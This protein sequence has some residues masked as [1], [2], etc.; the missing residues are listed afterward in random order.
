MHSGRE[1]RKSYL[2]LLVAFF[3]LYANRW[4]KSPVSLPATHNPSFFAVSQY[5]AE[6]SYLLPINFKSNAFSV[7]MLCPFV[8]HGQAI[9]IGSLVTPLTNTEIQILH[10]KFRFYLSLLI[11]LLLPLK[12]Q[13]VLGRTNRLQQEYGEFY[14]A[15]V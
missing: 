2:L 7:S 14:L 6:P 11:L 3:T 15:V 1:F 4:G 13:K 10:Q 9:V 12:K 5:R 8:L